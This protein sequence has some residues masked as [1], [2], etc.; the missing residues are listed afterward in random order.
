MNNL[1]MRYQVKKSGTDNWVEVS[2]K[3]F[4][5]TLADRFDTLT[6]VLSKILQGEQIITSHEIFRRI[7]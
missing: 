6:P 7:N 4:M 5:E 1:R 3:I 2:E